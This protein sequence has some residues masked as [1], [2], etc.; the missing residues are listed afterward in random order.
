[1]LADS[2]EEEDDVEVAFEEGHDDEQGDGHEQ[3]DRCEE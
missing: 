1:G 3:E 2:D